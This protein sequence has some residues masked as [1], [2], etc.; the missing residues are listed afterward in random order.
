M[1]YEDMSDFEINEAVALAVDFTPSEI[2]IAVNDM[3]ENIRDC[4]DALLRMAMP[5]G[6]SF[7]GK[8]YCN[9]PSDAQSIIADNKIFII[10]DDDTSFAGVV[11]HWANGGKSGRFDFESDC[12]MHVN[13]LRAAMIA[14]LKIKEPSNVK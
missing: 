12:V 9:N 6:E 3:A 11:T 1:K 8:N 10:H 4:D 13:P 2:A 7:Y 14:F 5:K